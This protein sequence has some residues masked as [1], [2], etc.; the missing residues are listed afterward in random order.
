MA[1]HLWCRSTSLEFLFIHVIHLKRFCFV[2]RFHY[3]WH[4][5][6]VFFI[7]DFVLTRFWKRNKS[8][9]KL[10]E[11]YILMTAKYYANEH[12]NR[13]TKITRKGSSQR[14]SCF[15]LVCL[16]DVRKFNVEHDEHIHATE[17]W[18]KITTTN[19]ETVDHF[20][21]VATVPKPLCA[22]VKWTVPLDVSKNF[23]SHFDVVIIEVKRAGI[24]Y[25]EEEAIVWVG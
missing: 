11:V 13:N 21:N 6:L 10:Q 18:F 7:T 17:Q 15:A 14:I 4:S 25:G 24:M 19:I 2:I 12:Y 22:F 1:H 3:K 8:E 20:C 5:L 16:I 23:A 9:I